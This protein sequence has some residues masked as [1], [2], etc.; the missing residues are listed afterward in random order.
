MLMSKYHFEVRKFVFSIRFYGRYISF[1]VPKKSVET[2]IEIKNISWPDLPACKIIYKRSEISRRDLTEWDPTEIRGLLIWFY[3]SKNTI[4]TLVSVKITVGTIISYTVYRLKI[5]RRWHFK[6]IIW[7]F[8]YHP[9]RSKNK[10]FSD[11]VKRAKCA[12]H[13]IFKIN[14]QNL[15]Y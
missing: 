2:S 9:K 5:E 4:K 8:F 12:V 10:Y 3:F 1:N 14:L 15:R 11:F 13:K 6:G 7:F